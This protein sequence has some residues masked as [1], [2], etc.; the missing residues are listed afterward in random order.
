[1]T[2]SGGA[3][4]QTKAKSMYGSR[5]SMAPVWRTQL[6]VPVSI[7]Y[8][9]GSVKTI[10]KDWD[11]VGEDETVACVNC[12]LKD[13]EG[14]PDRQHRPKWF[15]LYGPPLV[16]PTSTE[17]AEIAL[18]MTGPSALTNW[19]SMYEN[20]PQKASTYRGR[21]LLSREIRENLPIGKEEVG[22]LPKKK[23]PSTSRF[24]MRCYVSSG[25]DVPYQ[26]SVIRMGLNFKMSVKIS[27][28]SAVLETR[29]VE[30]ANGVCEWGELLESKE[31]LVLPSDP[32]Q[33]P[34]AIVHLQR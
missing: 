7:P 34:D 32:E 22:R 3:P 23:E 5:S 13:I 8:M 21:I 10:V 16:V 20:L 4:A 31:P 12:K 17:I 15:S 28:G 19:R 24:A 29:L 30:N 26:A 27:I 33:I 25:A 9:S 1:V 6:W 18:R 11:S 2:V 14:L